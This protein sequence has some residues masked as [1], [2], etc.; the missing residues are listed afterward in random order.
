MQAQEENLKR[1]QEENN[2]FVQVICF[3]PML[4]TDFGSVFI[5]LYIRC[6][7]ILYFVDYYNH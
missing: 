7:L 6:V 5:R 2:M 1:R 4:I 3:G